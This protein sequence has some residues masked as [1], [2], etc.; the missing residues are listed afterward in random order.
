MRNDRTLHRFIALGA[1]LAAGCSEKPKP[2]PGG[3]TAAAAAA[4]AYAYV[5]NEDSH[6]LTIINADNDSVDRHHPRRDPPARREGEPRR[7]VRLRRPQRL[8]QVP[9]DDVRRGVREARLRQD[10]GRRGGRRCRDPDGDPG[11]ARAAPTRRR[12]TSRPMTRRSTC[13][14]RMPAW[15]PSWTSRPGRILATVP[16]ERNPRASRWRPTARRSGSAAKPTTTSRSSTPS[17]ARGSVG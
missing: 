16:T 13:R 4:S 1:L 8:A 2:E 7:Q 10:E 17:R 6:D 3:A 5:T 12:S 15:R 9:A 11:A 14:T